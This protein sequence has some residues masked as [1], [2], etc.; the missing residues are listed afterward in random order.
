METLE[1][2]ELILSMHILCLS[3]RETTQLRS[4]ELFLNGL[5]YQG[6]HV[7]ALG[8]FLSLFPGLPPP[9]R[10]VESLLCFSVTP[11][12]W[13]IAWSDENRPAQGRPR[14]VSFNVNQSHFNSRL[15]YKQEPIHPGIYSQRWIIFWRPVSFAW[16]AFDKHR[17]NEKN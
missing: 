11:K 5:K 6:L 9:F 12:D 16:K 7:K 8:F 1:E 15:L 14:L 2:A 13:V 10:A 4:L 3:G 17:N